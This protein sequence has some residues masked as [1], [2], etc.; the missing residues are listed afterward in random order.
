M[1][2]DVR[3]IERL[4]AFPRFMTKQNGDLGSHRY[5]VFVSIRSA[6]VFLCYPLMAGGDRV[7]EMWM[8]QSACQRPWISP[9]IGRKPA[10]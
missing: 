10:L 4:G 3:G 2:P 6:M 7:L 5:S 8:L 9:S 1:P